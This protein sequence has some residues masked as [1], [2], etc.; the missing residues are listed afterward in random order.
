MIFS[1]VEVPQLTF[2]VQSN[3]MPL[4][5]KVRFKTFIGEILNS[6]A[7]N[8]FVGDNFGELA[9]KLRLD[10]LKQSSVTH[11]PAEV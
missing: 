11:V 5:Y 9:L 3:Q 2:I 10:K 1:I 8:D 4:C 7:R 6:I